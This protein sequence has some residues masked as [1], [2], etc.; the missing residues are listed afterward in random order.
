MA[1]ASVSKDG[2]R[3]KKKEHSF[4]Y[5]SPPRRVLLT[6]PFHR[7]RDI[8]QNRLCLGLGPD[9]KVHISEAQHRATHSVGG[10]GYC[11][12]AIMVRTNFIR[13]GGFLHAVH[14]FVLFLWPSTADFFIH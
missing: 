1:R 4:R 3:G 13:L 9:D 8:G 10:V 5:L 14:S 12:F 7:A 11:G 6:S 2:V